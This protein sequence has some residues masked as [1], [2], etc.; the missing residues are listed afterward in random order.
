MLYMSLQ[1]NRRWMRLLS[2]EKYDFRPIQYFYEIHEKRC[3]ICLETMNFFKE[4]K[5]FRG[6]RECTFWAHKA[7]VTGCTICPQ[8]RCGFR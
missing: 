7:C 6:C 2:I 8:C 1:E 3:P 4:F 5:Y